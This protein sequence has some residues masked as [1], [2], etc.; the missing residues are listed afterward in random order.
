MSDIT[1]KRCIPCHGTGKI[2][3]GGM[4][5]KVCNNC[6]GAGKVEFYR[7]EIEVLAIAQKA[8]K[9]INKDDKK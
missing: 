7:D 4:V 6:N 5:E 9:R 3:G 8:K 2:I 1:Y